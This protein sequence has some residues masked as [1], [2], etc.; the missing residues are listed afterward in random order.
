VLVDPQAVG[1]AP[2]GRARRPARRGG[3]ERLVDVDAAGGLPRRLVAVALELAE[4]RRVHQA[5]AAL[6]RPQRRGDRLAEEAGD[7]HGGAGVGVER[8]E[9]AL[10]P[11]ARQRGLDR[12]DPRANALREALERGRVERAGLKAHPRL[13][14]H[15]GER[16]VRAVH[17]WCVAGG[18]RSGAALGTLPSSPSP[19]SSL[20]LE[21]KSGWAGSVCVWVGAAWVA[22][23]LRRSAG[24]APARSWPARKARTIRKSATVPAARGRQEVMGPWSA[25]SLRVG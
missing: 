6:G 3:G 4:E 2:G 18:A 23:A 10:R 13:A 11:E 8:V 5:V 17:D 20:C 24:S 7:G 16:E 15:G 19:P 21:P 25:P 12:V 1:D 22:A 14:A 9:L